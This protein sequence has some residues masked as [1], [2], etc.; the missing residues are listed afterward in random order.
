MT[1][2]RRDE[3]LSLLRLLDKE[4]ERDGVCGELY[5]VG[6]AVLCVAFE[7][8]RGAREVDGFFHPARTVRMAARRVAENRGLPED[9]LNEAVRRFFGGDVREHLSLSNLRVQT[10][11][12]E[13][14]LAMKCLSVRSGGGFHDREDV[15]FL[16]RDL[17]V[18][19]YDAALE[20][21][22]RYYPPD[23]IPQQARAAL[24]EMIADIA[25]G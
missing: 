15:R 2:L 1:A 24:Q 10:A 23:K 5:L 14:L 18:E 17:N 12:S 9:W 11:R 19:R 16:L 21:V 4:L 8:G 13:Y 7:A 3:I 6:G 25:E 22:A 20:T